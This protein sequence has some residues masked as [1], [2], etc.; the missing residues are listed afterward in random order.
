MSSLGFYDVYGT[1]DLC[2]FCPISSSNITSLSKVR[3]MPLLG[4]L[5]LNLEE[6]VTKMKIF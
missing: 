2:Y 5:N 6:N 4:P 1:A 3:N